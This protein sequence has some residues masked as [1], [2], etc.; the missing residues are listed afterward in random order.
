MQSETIEVLL[1]TVLL[2]A[3]VIPCAMVVYRICVRLARPDLDDATGRY[4]SAMQ[5][6]LT[7]VRDILTD[8]AV[9]NGDIQPLPGPMDS[10]KRMAATLAPTAGEDPADVARSLLQAVRYLDPDLAGVY[11][12]DLSEEALCRTVAAVKD[13]W[14][15]GTDTPYRERS[16]AE[17]LFV[18][19]ETV[20]RQFRERYPDVEV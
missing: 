18:R 17:R 4:V 3:V 5:E 6:S 8:L 19:W 7:L 11:G 1:Q 20:V 9:Q 13:E 16:R 12:F 14:L 2:L 15:G 10:L